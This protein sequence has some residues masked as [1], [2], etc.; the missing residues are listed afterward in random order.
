[1]II[2]GKAREFEWKDATNRK[3]ELLAVITYVNLFIVDT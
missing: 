2:L 3:R 1:M